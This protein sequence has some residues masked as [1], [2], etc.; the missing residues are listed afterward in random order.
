MPASRSCPLP[1]D[2]THLVT[3]TPA[4]FI[5]TTQSR[6]C[7]RTPRARPRHAPRTGER[8]AAGAGWAAAPLSSMQV[9]RSQDEDLAHH[10]RALLVAAHEPDH[11]TTGRGFDHGFESVAHEIL[12]LH[13]LPGSPPNRDRPQ[14]ASAQP[15]RNHR[16]ADRRRGRPGS[17]T[18]RATD[19]GHRTPFSNATIPSEHR[20]Q[21][22]AAGTRSDRWISSAHGRRSPQP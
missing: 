4:A 10:V 19:H 2:D 20:R 16:A 1:V 12:K 17:R 21:H 15:A 7:A 22:I 13:A 6:R 14:A 11:V 9:G 18:S 5:S 3:R 8:Q